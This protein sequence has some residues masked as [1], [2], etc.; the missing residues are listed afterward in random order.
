MMQELIDLKN[1]VA[2]MKSLLV[3]FLENKIEKAYYTPAEVGKRLGMAADTVRKYV[4]L[5]KIKGTRQGTQ[6]LISHDELAR[7]QS[8]KIPDEISAVDHN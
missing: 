5:G 7:L 3:S 2:E 4:R 1:E 6:V 8:R